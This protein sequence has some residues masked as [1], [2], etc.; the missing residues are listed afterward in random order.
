[1]GVAL[2]VEGSV[3]HGPRDHCAR[4]WNETLLPALGR[5]PVTCIVPIGKDAITRL[6]NLRASTSAPGLDARIVDS[7][8]RHGLDPARD[9][10]VIAW[11]LEP[12]DRGQ[13][14]CAWHEKLGVYRGLAGSSLPGLQNTPWARSAAA[15][16]EALDRCRGRPPTG[17]SRSVVGPGTVLGVCMEPMF[18]GLL[19]HDGR[20]V[21][22]AMGLGNDPRN[23]PADRRWSPEER[24]PSTMLL[25]AAVDAMREIRP[26][27]PIRKLIRAV[28]D[29][30]KDEWCEYLLRQ[31]LADP[32]QAAAIRA[33]PIARRLL[34]ILPPLP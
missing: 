15:R 32:A 2:F 29:E 21:R 7:I 17:Q 12:V 26:K 3:P 31:L 18:E 34:H 20:A 4:L 9:A 5:A 13:P 30:A 22:R 6:R 19:A 28:Y 27:P 10:L 25:A 11:D 33:H 14:R 24:D 8:T 16:A 1:M 23:W